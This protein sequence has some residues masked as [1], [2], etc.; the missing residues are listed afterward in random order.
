MKWWHLVS[1]GILT[2]TPNRLIYYF[3]INRPV[4]VYTNMQA[5][6]GHTSESTAYVVADYPYGY[7]TRTSIR[8]WLESKPGKGWRFVSQTLNPKTDRWNKPKA[9][10]YVAF[11]AAMYLDDQDHVAWN[12]LSGYS[13]G[14]EIL[15]F[16]KDFPTADMGA[17][18]A[19]VPAK[20]AYLRKLASG[21]AVWTVTINGVAEPR[22]EAKIEADK[23]EAAKD[24]K[25]WEEIA[26]LIVK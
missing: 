24:L 22:N 4:G 16:V 11:G 1:A 13:S 5:L 14:E 19:F 17:L 25:V 12:G 8:Y 15:K 3:V 26:A 18:R 10:T 2:Y 21:A 20:L 7:T 6:T 9:S 23:A